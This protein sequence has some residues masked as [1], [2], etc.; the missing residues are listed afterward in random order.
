MTYGPKKQILKLQTPTVSLPF[1]ISTF[2]DA[3]KGTT[4]E[5]PDASLR[6]WDDP[7]SPVHAL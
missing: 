5:S 2:T 1:G 6:G 4:T 7:S 3:D